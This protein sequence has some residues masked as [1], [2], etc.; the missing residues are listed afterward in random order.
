MP[1]CARV[2]YVR[3]EELG[4]LP[5]AK[6]WERRRGS[7]GVCIRAG[8]SVLRVGLIPRLGND[9]SIGRDEIVILESRR[10][11]VYADAEYTSFGDKCFYNFV[12]GRGIHNDFGFAKNL[13]Q[14]YK[15]CHFLQLNL[16]G[17]FK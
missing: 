10:F 5:I 13:C 12:G 9:G 6:G 16:Y 14:L 3:I 15:R 4:R 17:F 11:E 7:E 2:I 8:L 1:F